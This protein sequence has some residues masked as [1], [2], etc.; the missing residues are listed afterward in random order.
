MS[1][2]TALFTKVLNDRP[3][4]EA[5][6]LTADIG[7]D[8]VEPMGR[9]P[10]LSVDMPL[11]RVEELGAKIDALDLTVPCIATYTG[12]YIGKTDS[13]CEEQL[14]KLEQFCEFA[15]VLGCDL[16]RHS[17]G[18]PPVRDASKDNY[19]E[20]TEWMRRAAD[21]AADYDK[22]LG[23]EIHGHTITETADATLKLLEMI[24]RTNVG[25]IHDAG[26]MYLVDDDYERKTV[27]ALGDQLFHVHVKD[28]RRVEDG[29]MT[30]AFEYENDNGVETFQPTLLGDGD[31]DYRPLF[32][33]LVE[34]DYDG[35]ITDECH[36][37]SDD[38]D[39]DVTIAKSELAALQDHLPS[40]HMTGK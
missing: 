6:E 30:G 12:F 24:D 20:A 14:N 31:V 34:Y 23:I 38:S 22:R 13:E 35:F 37:P 40:G 11:E 21:I 5:V 39:G 28:E 8:G 32:E 16:V 27:K 9:E 19:A 1:I 26:N 2:R 33:A 10:H 36:V 7:Y 3:L 29:S 4:G 18:G 25:A 15:D 17:P